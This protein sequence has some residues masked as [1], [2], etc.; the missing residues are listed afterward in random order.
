[1]AILKFYKIAKVILTI[2]KT[3]VPVIEEIWGKDL[4]GD[5]KVGK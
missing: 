2:G 1:M 4:N 3:L 5:G